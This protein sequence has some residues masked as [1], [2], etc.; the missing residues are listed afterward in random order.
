[1]LFEVANIPIFP[2]VA[3]AGIDEGVVPPAI[4]EL[5]IAVRSVGHGGL[6]L[7]DGFHYVHRE[8]QSDDCKDRFRIK[9]T[10]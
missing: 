8:Q 5:N 9:I 4:R 10:D 2:N 6:G 7:K 1:M 3:T